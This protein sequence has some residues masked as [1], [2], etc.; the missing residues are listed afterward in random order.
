VGDFTQMFIGM[1]EQVRV[2]VLNELYAATGQLA[3][4]VHA[5]ADVALAHNASF[6]RLKGIIP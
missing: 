6:C 3:L 2:F 5:R 4:I 1:R